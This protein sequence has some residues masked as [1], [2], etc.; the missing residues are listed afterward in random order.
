[1]QPIIVHKGRTTRISVGLGFD[2]SADTFE[3]EIRVDQ[4]PTSTLIATWAISFLT[5][6]IDG[7]L[8]LTLDDSVSGPITQSKGYMDIKRITGGEPVPAF[9]KPL[10][11]LFQKTVTA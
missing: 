5:D 3:S 7:E 9:D 10:E 1:M 11:V 4:D 6:G 8:V 2:V